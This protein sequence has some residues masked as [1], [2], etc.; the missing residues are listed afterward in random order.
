MKRRNLDNVE[1]Q[2]RVYPVDLVQRS[3][4]LFLEADTSATEQPEVVSYRIMS[5]LKK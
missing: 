1:W 5:A 2:K 4:G 3:E